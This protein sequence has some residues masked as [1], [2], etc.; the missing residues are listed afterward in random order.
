V[1]GVLRLSQSLGQTLGQTS[2]ET[3]LPTVPE[4]ARGA[5]ESQSRTSVVTLLTSM[6]AIADAKLQ[7]TKHTTQYFSAAASLR[8]SRGSRFFAFAGSHLP[9]AGA[10]ISVGVPPN[11]RFWNAIRGYFSRAH[12]SVTDL[13]ISWFG[14]ESRRVNSYLVKLSCHF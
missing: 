2:R 7:K 11:Q 1:K 14:R 5:V 13:T 4:K 3:W 6:P 12:Y 10:G 9:A 8:I